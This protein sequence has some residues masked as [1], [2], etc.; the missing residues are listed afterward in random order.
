MEISVD[1][2]VKKYQAGDFAYLLAENARNSRF[3]IG[4]NTSTSLTH[5]T[6]QANKRLLNP[7]RL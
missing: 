3:V 7:D 6:G 1:G 5:V 4:L 2:I